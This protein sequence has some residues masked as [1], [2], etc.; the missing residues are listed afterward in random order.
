MQDRIA[1]LDVCEIAQN[2]FRWSILSGSDVATLDIQYNPQWK[3]TYARRSFFN[4][5]EHHY[6]L[7][8][9]A[10]SKQGIMLT[11]TIQTVPL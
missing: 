7:A 3:T 6:E 5:V 10:T 2:Q 4:S 9:R 1:R 11:W 8:T